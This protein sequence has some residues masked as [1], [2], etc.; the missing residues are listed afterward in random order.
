MDKKENPQHEAVMPLLLTSVEVQVTPVLI[1]EDALAGLW[2]IELPS[3]LPA[4]P[5]HRS[6]PVRTFS[7]GELLE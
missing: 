7:Q 6:S 3:I 5:P 4:S 1:P 2:P